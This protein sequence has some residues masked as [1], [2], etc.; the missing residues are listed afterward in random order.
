MSKETLAERR[1]EEN[2]NE[3]TIKQDAAKK[4]KT[5]L[6]NKSKSKSKNMKSMTFL[7][8]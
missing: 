8:H 7:G 4:L 3:E 6:K 5:G 1:K 2:S